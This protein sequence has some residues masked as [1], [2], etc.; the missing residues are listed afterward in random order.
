MFNLSLSSILAKV[1]ILLVCLPIHEAAHAGVAYLLGDDTAKRQGRLTLNPLAH[2]DPLGGLM[3]LIASIGWAKP[4]PVNP[5]R[6]R[7][8]PRVGYAIT[9]AA[10]PLSNL[11]LAIV[12]VLPFRLGLLHVMSINENLRYF[13][14]YFVAINIGLALFN[15]IPLAPLDGISVLRGIVDARTS[16][17]LTPLVAYGPYILLILLLMGNVAP[18]L[19]VLGKLLSAGMDGALRLLLGF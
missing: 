14:V 5:A 11:L 1:V 7:Y 12:A 17:L 3:L 13:F 10:G 6:L 18:S 9:A 16:E 19:D 2:L 8:G 4:V 15:L